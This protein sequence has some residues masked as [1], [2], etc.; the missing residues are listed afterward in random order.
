MSC[1]FFTFTVII[2]CSISKCSLLIIIDDTPNE[3]TRFS[4]DKVELNQDFSTPVDSVNHTGDLITHPTFKI[5]EYE[6]QLCQL[7]KSASVADLL[8]HIK[9]NHPTSLIQHPQCC[10]CKQSE[11]PL[12][13]GNYNARRNEKIFYHNVF[14]Y[15]AFSVYRNGI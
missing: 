11:Y 12:V 14:L 7:Y 15:G 2:L 13:R 4:E 9:Q 6:C 5:D 8:S 10:V 3:R 1:C